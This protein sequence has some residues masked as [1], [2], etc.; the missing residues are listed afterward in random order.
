MTLYI[1]RLGLIGLDRDSKHASIELLANIIDRIVPLLLLHV[2]KGPHAVL[3][4]QH[5]VL[6]STVHAEARYEKRTDLFVLGSRTSHCELFEWFSSSIACSCIS[7]GALNPSSTPWST[8][9]LYSFVDFFDYSFEKKKKRSE[10][11][12][13]CVARVCRFH[14]CFHEISVEAMWS[15]VRTLVP[16]LSPFA[17]PQDDQKRTNCICFDQRFQRRQNLFSSR[18]SMPHFSNNI[19]QRKTPGGTARIRS[20]LLKVWSVSFQSRKLDILYLYNLIYWVGKTLTLLTIIC[21]KKN[22]VWCGQVHAYS[23]WSI[24][25]LTC[26]KVNLEKAGLV[27]SK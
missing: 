1:I 26:Y 24:S 12:P 8:W 2:K 10:S 11:G 17:L 5:L 19:T 22:G 16:K 7:K 9:H 3:E 25:S 4:G 21:K 6:G 27:R 23:Q 14:F 18:G 20:K 15:T 13:S